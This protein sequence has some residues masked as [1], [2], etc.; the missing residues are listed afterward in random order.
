MGEF[1]ASDEQ[2]IEGISAIGTVFEEILFR[3]SQLFAS[4]VLVKA[5]AS[6][7]NPCSLN[8]ENQV[9]VI[10][11]IKERHEALLPSESL[12]D[13]QVFLIM[14]HRTPEIDIIP[15]FRAS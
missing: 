5:I 12:V 3:F 1:L 4:F 2:G 14:P 11:A 6:T 15:V 9:I 8:S 7:S 13:E 10:L